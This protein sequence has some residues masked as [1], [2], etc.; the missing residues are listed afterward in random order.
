MKKRYVVLW[1]TSVLFVIVFLYSN[2]KETM[3]SDETMTP[4]L[5]VGQIQKPTGI[6]QVSPQEAV[7]KGTTDQKEKGVRPHIEKDDTRKSLHALLLRTRPS[8]IE[9]RHQASFYLHA[10]RRLFAGKITSRDEHELAKRWKKVDQDTRKKIETRLQEFQTLPVYVQRRVVTDLFIQRPIDKP[11]TL[12]DVNQAIEQET[13]GKVCSESETKICRN[14]IEDGKLLLPEGSQSLAIEPSRPIA[15][16]AAGN[17][18]LLLIDTTIPNQPKF[19]TTPVQPYKS[20][21]TGFVNDVFKVGVP[22]VYLMAITSSKVGNSSGAFELVDVSNPTIPLLLSSIQG[23]YFKIAVTSDYQWAFSYNVEK[24]E[25]HVIGLS[26][27]SSPTIRGTLPY[28]E[29]VADLAFGNGYLEVLQANGL[30]TFYSFNPTGPPFLIWAGGDP[31]ANQCTESAAADAVAE[32]IFSQNYALIVRDGDF[33]IVETTPNTGG[34]ATN[35]RMCSGNKHNSVTVAEDG[36]IILDSLSSS[37]GRDNRGNIYSCSFV[38]IDYYSKPV[39]DTDGLT[40]ESSINLPNEI[41]GIASK[42]DRVYVADYAQTTN[43]KAPGPEPVHFR[44]FTQ[45]KVFKKYADI[46]PTIETLNGIKM[47]QEHE[48]PTSECG[49][50][51]LLCVNHSECGPTGY[52]S[53]GICAQPPVIDVS[54]NQQVILTGKNYWDINAKVLIQ[55]LGSSTWVPFDAFVQGDEFCELADKMTVKLDTSVTNPGIKKI[56]I[57]NYNSPPKLRTCVNCNNLDDNA[58]APDFVDSGEILVYFRKAAASTPG[59]AM[60]VTMIQANNGTNGWMDLGPNAWYDDE[61]FLVSSQPGDTGQTI[62]TPRPDTYPEGFE[63]KHNGEYRKPNTEVVYRNPNESDGIFMPSVSLWESDDERTLGAL[64]ATL[65][66]ACV[67]GDVVAELCG[68]PCWVVCG[69]VAAVGILMAIF[70]GGDMFVVESG[71]GLAITKGVAQQVL[72]YGACALPP[73][74]FVGTSESPLK[75]VYVGPLQTLG[76][77]KYRTI[78]KVFSSNVA[79]EEYTEYTIEYTLTE[80]P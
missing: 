37:R 79:D 57:R 76:G 6:M 3:A 10:L 24:A 61:T 40:F 26:N 65:G 68:L 18:G 39:Y 74:W 47:L 75:S 77:I 38:S 64:L 46:N 21:M 32:A 12:L 19:F 59:F 23:S 2:F 80:R 4:Q 45:P 20:A 8:P 67:V 49:S 28:V 34:L 55:N 72:Q 22:P 27:L 33:H 13:A 16:V 66:T 73:S 78:T 5:I 71:D 63:F 52:C 69:G 53:G 1:V 7:P 9:I 54:D 42:S 48:L 43:C 44:V 14:S 41:K 11:L 58:C 30:S 50:Q 62:I 60:H 29:K 36:R 31:I 15:G 56:K 17:T 35:M 25:I 70:D 51:L